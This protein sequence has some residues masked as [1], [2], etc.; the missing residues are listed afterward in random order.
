MEVSFR[1]LNIPLLQK[2]GEKKPFF[3]CVSETSHLHTSLLFILGFVA[4]R[5]EVF[6]PLPLLNIVPEE[7]SA[8]FKPFSRVFHFSLLKRFAIEVIRLYLENSVSLLGPLISFFPPS[9][10]LLYH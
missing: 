10:M 7:R 9:T 3:Y 2:E 6:P 1:P 8:S 4:G 5:L